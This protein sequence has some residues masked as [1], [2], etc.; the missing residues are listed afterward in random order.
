MVKWWE[1]SHYYALPV[2]LQFFCSTFASKSQCGNLVEKCGNLGVELRLSPQTAL[3]FPECTMLMSEILH[4]ENVLLVALLPPFFLFLPHS[5]CGNA[6]EFIRWCS[7]FEITW[8]YCTLPPDP[9]VIYLYFSYLFIYA[10]F[11]FFLLIFLHLLS[12]MSSKGSLL[13][14]HDT[15]NKKLMFS[16]K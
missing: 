6:A 1:I 7:E 2:L 15:W 5:W 9:L 11:F 4:V 12:V 3:D 8:S 10:F 16:K 13:S 14:S